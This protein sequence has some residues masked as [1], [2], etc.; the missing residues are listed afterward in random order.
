ME[1]YIKMAKKQQTKITPELFNLDLVAYRWQLS[2]VSGY[3]Y[4]AGKIEPY[5]VIQDALKAKGLHPL[6]VIDKE[7]FSPKHWQDIL[8]VWSKLD[9][10]VLSQKNK[11]NYLKVYNTLK[12]NNGNS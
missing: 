4:K 6:I 1:D 9:I 11:E 3:L 7:V 8:S 2:F 5:G 10:D 12:N